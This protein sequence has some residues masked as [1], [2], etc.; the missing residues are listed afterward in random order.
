MP[1]AQVT[2]PFVWMCVCECCYAVSF[3]YSNVNGVLAG[4]TQ[5][6]FGG[7]NKS[8]K[9]AENQLQHNYLRILL[10]Y[11]KMLGFSI[12]IVIGIGSLV[13]NIASISSATRAAYYL[14]T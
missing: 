3:V 13:A 4:F 5:R 7:V 12:V 1:I 8:N 14:W 11:Q 6:T 10:L 2:E 9:R